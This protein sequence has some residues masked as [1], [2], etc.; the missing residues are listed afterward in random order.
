MI[1]VSI[2]VPRSFWCIPSSVIARRDAAKG[3]H[4]RRF[5]IRSWYKSADQELRVHKHI[6]IVYSRADRH[7]FN[8]SVRVLLVHLIKYFHKDDHWK[9]CTKRTTSKVRL[10]LAEVELVF[11]LREIKILQRFPTPTNY[12]NFLRRRRWVSFH[13]FL[14]SWSWATEDKDHFMS[15][16]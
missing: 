12:S 15:L 3:P 4:L 1:D 9:G 7:E 2:L 16:I 5:W 13:W 11:Y 6:C 8:L 14:Q 10:P